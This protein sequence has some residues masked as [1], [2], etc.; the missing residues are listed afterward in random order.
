MFSKCK[1]EN[2]EITEIREM[3]LTKECL[4]NVFGFFVFV[5]FLP[6]D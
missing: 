3:F 6:V 4:L 1:Q 5:F 2:G